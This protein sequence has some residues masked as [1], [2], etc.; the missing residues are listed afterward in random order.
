MCFQKK[1]GEA[2]YRKQVEQE[3]ERDIKPHESVFIA[4]R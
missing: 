3:N 2:N 4:K 1:G